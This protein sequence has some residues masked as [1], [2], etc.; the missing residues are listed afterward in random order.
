MRRKRKREDAPLIADGNSIRRTEREVR[1]PPPP[2]ACA[3]VR[4]R[5]RRGRGTRDAYGFRRP[6]KRKRKGKNERERGEEEMKRE[7]AGERE[8]EVISPSRARKRGEALLTPLL[9]TETISVARR[10]E[11]RER[12]K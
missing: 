9:P 11:E 12:E 5:G 10:C 3:R 6:R 7:R 1:F 2:H 8:G 4:E